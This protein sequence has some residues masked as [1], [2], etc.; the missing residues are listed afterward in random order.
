MDTKILFIYDGQCPFC[1]QFAEL[2]ELKS[3]LPNIEVKNA[4]DY[5]DQIPTGYDMDVK[6]AI[7]YRNDQM[8][9]G[10][11]AINWI[12]SQIQEPSDALL[13]IL[14]L[15]FISKK[16]SNLIFPLLLIA[17]RIALFFKGVPNKLDH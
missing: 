5:P 17:R 7:L 3:N 10:A 12:C 14:K 8:L 2:L 1:N 16:R 4:R 11:K 9:T 6:G 13:D 15:V